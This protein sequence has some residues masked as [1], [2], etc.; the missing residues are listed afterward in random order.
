[1]KNLIFIL[2]L[3]FGINSS[4]QESFKKKYSIPVKFGENIYL[5]KDTIVMYNDMNKE[6]INKIDEIYTGVD[7]VE[8]NTEEMINGKKISITKNVKFD[9]IFKSNLSVVRQIK[10]ID[11][12]IKGFV[13]FEENGKIIVNRYLKKDSVDNYTKYPIHY[14]QLQNRQSIKL[15]FQEVTVTALILPFKYRPKSKNKERKEDFNTAINGNIFIGYSIGK[16]SFF[17]REKVGN[18]SN[19]WKV[20]P[21]LLVGASSVVLDKNNTDLSSTPIIDDSKFTKGLASMALGITYSF[22]KI[23]FGGFYGYDYVIGDG[24]NSW[25]YNKKPWY[26]I[27]IGYS[28]LNF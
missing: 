4:G 7:F 25:N 28:I 23:N 11:K 8:I 26:G 21:G 16:T 6:E 19:T 24:A 9:S 1:M 3:L 15:C 17:H 12:G 22:N 13:K 27:A 5:L 2:L 18:K 20:T 14:Y 10:V